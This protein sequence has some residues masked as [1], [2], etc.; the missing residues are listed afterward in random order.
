M[1][2]Y[3]PYLLHMLHL[4]RPRE[5]TAS[6]IVRPPLRAILLGAA[7]AVGAAAAPALG[8][9]PREV[10]A[11]AGAATGPL[12]VLDPA[13]LVLAPG[14]AVRITVWRKPELS[15]EFVVAT[16]GSLT[17]PLYRV[18]RV[19]GVPLTTAEERVRVF[20]EQLEVN[21]QFVVEPLL[22]VAVGGEVMRPNLYTLRPETTIAMA[23]AMAGGNTERGRRDRVRL[24][25][26]H[27]EIIL[28]LTRP[29]VGAA[30][31]PI[32]SGDQILVDRRHA[33]FREYV[34]PAITVAGATAAILNAIFRY[35]DR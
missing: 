20:L 34:A 22:R 19:G 8:Q 17:H 3:V 31:M 15:G 11:R 6:P 28:D 9:G 18:V 10:A 14:D 33:V 32:R 7:C 30:Q 5:R 4:L 2:L 23:V 24:L 13:A 27:E 21:P 1:R 35:R 29:E 12:S 25:R 26:G 16:D